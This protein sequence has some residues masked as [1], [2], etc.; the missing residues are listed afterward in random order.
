VFA[1][2]PNGAQDHFEPLTCDG[3]PHTYTIV[4]TDANGVAATRSLTISTQRQ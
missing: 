2:Y 4:A 3:K 1:R